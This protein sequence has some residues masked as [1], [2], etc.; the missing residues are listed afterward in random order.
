MA[1]RM[2]FKMR[3]VE[4]YFPHSIKVTS[5]GFSKYLFYGEDTVWNHLSSC[6]HTAGLEMRGSPVRRG[7]QVLQKDLEEQPWEGW[8]SS[9]FI[10]RESRQALRGLGMP[11]GHTRGARGVQPLIWVVL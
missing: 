3:G 2:K 1:K 11:K 8:R 5:K 7:E 9:P 4:W 6:P 10:L